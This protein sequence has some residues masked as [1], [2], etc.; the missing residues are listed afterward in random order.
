MKGQERDRRPARVEVAKDRAYND[1]GRDSGRQRDGDG[2]NFVHL[3]YGNTRSKHLSSSKVV[4]TLQAPRAQPLGG[5][6]SDS[7]SRQHSHFSSATIHAACS[8]DAPPLALNNSIMVDNAFSILAKSLGRGEG[9]P[10]IPA[11]RSM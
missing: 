3:I 7:E 9:M 5:D 6:E 10:D 4:Q 8:Y 2:T 1:G 11:R